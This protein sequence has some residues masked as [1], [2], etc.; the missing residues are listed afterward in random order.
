MGAVNE[1]PLFFPFFEQEKVAPV[2]ALASSISFKFGV[3]VSFMAA[4]T[5]AALFIGYSILTEISAELDTLSGKRAPEARAGTELILASDGV[6]TSLMELMKTGTESEAKTA[7]GE[8]AVHL[9]AIDDFVKDVPKEIAEDIVLRR[10]AASQQLKALLDTHTELLATRAEIADQVA[11]LNELSEAIRIQMSE[12]SAWASEESRKAGVGALETIESTM[13]SLVERDAAALRAALTVRGDLNLAAGGMVA[14]SQGPSPALR[15]IL[16]DII[17]RSLGAAEASAEV[18]SGMEGLGAYGEEIIGVVA[19]LRQMIATGRFDERAALAVRGEAD[20]L[21][22]AAVDDIEFA[23]AIAASDAVDNSRSSISDMVDD[24]QMR[25]RELAALETSIN[26]LVMA[27]LEAAI[28]PDKEALDGASTRASEAAGQVAA[29]MANAPGLTMEIEFL[30][31]AADA[32]DGV[33][34]KR[35]RF[36]RARDWAVGAARQASEGASGL[37]LAA[38]SAVVNALDQIKGSSA[39]LDGAIVAAKSRMSTVAAAAAVIFVLVQLVAFRLIAKPIRILTEETERLAEGDLSELRVN[40]GA[41]EVGRMARALCVFRDNSLAKQRLETEEKETERRIAADTARREEEDRIRDEADRKRAEAEARHEAEEARRREREK[42][43]SEEAERRAAEARRREQAQREKKEAERAEKLRREA[44]AEREEQARRQKA[45]VDALASGLESLSRGDLCAE[46]T[47]TFPQEY[48]RLRLDFN[49]A[50]A[51]LRGA[52]A[53]IVD[54]S[55]GIAATA[56]GID[57]SAERLSTAT[58][59]SAASLEESAAAVKNLSNSI[60]ATAEGSG[61]ARN[62]ADE[63]ETRAVAGGEVV[64]R[65]VAAMNAIEA[66]SAKIETI[67]AMI[68]DIAFQTNLLSLNA[69]V[70]AARAGESGR[71]FAVVAAEVRALAGRSSEAVAEINGLI[72]DSVTEIKSGVGLVGEAGEAL[73]GISASI[74]D[75][76]AR[77]RDIAGEADQQAKEISEVSASISQLDGATQRNAATAEETTAA[78]REM[79][80]RAKEMQEAALRFR[81]ESGAEETPRAA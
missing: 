24:K 18:L 67:T 63:A 53:E 16:L 33:A 12:T 66:S 62:A 29:K 25:M 68:E 5:T 70:E 77:I 41:G 6:R 43:E 19:E 78:S 61:Q 57:A 34:A 8:V 56:D 14:L 81:I 17:E 64:T 11:S 38:R 54:H 48:D 21:L 47:S 69:G 40:G 9:A 76:S 45:V 32:D 23:F 55:S 51:G 75:V 15:S 44:E 37:A 39:D 22:S 10:N 60:S 31:L 80:L 46:I 3:I 50:L 7:A 49:A 58:E 74:A 71:G 72:R 65:A 13:D 1:P 35:E 52:L 27:A 79:R 26:K 42:R 36:L 59:A 2:K 30:L 73:S 28:A 20:R 4:M